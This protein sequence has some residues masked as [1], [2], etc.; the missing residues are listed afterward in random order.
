Q[1]IQAAGDAWSSGIISQANATIHVEVIFTNSIPRATGRSTT[2]NFVRNNGVANVFEEGAASLYNGR[3]FPF[4]NPNSDVE[5]QLNPSYLSDFLWFD[6]NPN[7]RTAEVP[8]NRIDAM[9]VMLHEI[10]HAIAF[11][12]WR[13]HFT[14]NLPIQPGL[15]DAYMSTFDENISIANG[16]QLFTGPTAQMIYGRPIPI[17]YGNSNHIGNG[18]ES[19][20][21]GNDL[22]PDLM[23]G[24][25]FYYGQR[26][27]I[28]I[29]DWAILQDSG[30]QVVAVPEPTSTAGLLTTF[31]ILSI[32][33]IRRKI[34]SRSILKI[35]HEHPI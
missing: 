19:G 22:V 15:P 4:R 20:R 30:L 24:V 1:H 3:E 7:T 32:Q 9:S 8:F 18:V 14:G 31:A 26:Y 12:G 35:D 23:N 33:R 17:T 6:P 2:A 11:N 28:S 25:V 5:I 34:R 13:D 27:T 10:G 16:N 21:P 29:L